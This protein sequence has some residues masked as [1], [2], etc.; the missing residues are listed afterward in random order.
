MGKEEEEEGRLVN[1]DGEEEREGVVSLALLVL[2][3]D[4]ET[5]SPSSCLR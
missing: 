1:K 5:R 3:G 2:C 4:A